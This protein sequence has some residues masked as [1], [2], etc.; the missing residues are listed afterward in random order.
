M[1]IRSLKNAED[2]FFC[3]FKVIFISFYFAQDAQALVTLS[4]LSV[5]G[6]I[7]VTKGRMAF[8]GHLLKHKAS[9]HSDSQIFESTIAKLFSILMAP[10]GH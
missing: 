6:T 2:I 4:L 5:P 7:P 8:V 1:Q 9:E 3:V 10:C